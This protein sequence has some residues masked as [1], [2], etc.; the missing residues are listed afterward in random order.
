MI[1][2]IDNFDSFVFNLARYLEELGEETQVVRNDAITVDA[3]RALHP[4]AIVLSP[5]PCDPPKA[6]ITLDVVRE[7][8]KRTPMLG[9]CLGHQAIGEA[10]GARI[11]R[12]PP[13]HGRAS[14][15]L[16]DG[17][18]IFRGLPNPIEV[19]RYHSLAIERESLPDC[20]EVSASTSDACIMAVRHRELPIVGVQFHPESVLTE[21][22]HDLLRNFLASLPSRFPESEEAAPCPRPS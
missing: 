18:G 19:A 21:L 4:E 10:F 7:L 2:L 1:L 20:L 15:V 5:G 11:I 9:V 16:H 17:R 13:V 14:L 8:G 6:G 22:G 3:I 12:N